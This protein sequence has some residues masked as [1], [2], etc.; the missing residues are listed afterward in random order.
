MNFDTGSEKGDKAVM[1]VI[2]SFGEERE[3][4]FQVFQK[5][6]SQDRFRYLEQ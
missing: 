1:F 3:D 6:F 5:R 2:G 4:T